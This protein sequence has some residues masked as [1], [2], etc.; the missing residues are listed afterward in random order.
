METPRSGGISFL[1][2]V[3]LIT[4]NVRITPDLS[5]FNTSI[6]I[7]CLYVVNASPDILIVPPELRLSLSSFKPI[8]RDSIPGKVQRSAPV[9]TKAITAILLPV[10]GLTNLTGTFNF[11]LAFS[12]TMGYFCFFKTRN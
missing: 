4:S 8:V 7:W 9:S 5:F 2:K 12:M 6:L 3:L 10:S 1:S 11:A